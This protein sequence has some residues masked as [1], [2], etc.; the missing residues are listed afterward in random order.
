MIPQRDRLVLGLIIAAGLLLWKLAVWLW[1]L[2]F[3]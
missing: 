1:K 2:V 3:G